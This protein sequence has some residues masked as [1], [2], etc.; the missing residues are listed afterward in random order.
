MPKM[1]P[2]SQYLG[3]GRG[4]F[5]KAL[6]TILLNK[7]SKRDAFEVAKKELGNRCVYCGDK[8]ALLQPD[9]LWPATI[10]GL[11]VPGNVV[12]ACPSCN[13]DRGSKHWEKYIRTSN[14]VALEKSADEIG[15]QVTEIRSYMKKYE[16]EEEP[17]IEQMLTKEEIQLRDNFNILLD[18]L[19]QGI[20]AKLNDPQEK[21]VQFR[22]CS[23]MFDDL[24]SVAKKYKQ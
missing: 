12:P 5:R 11:F 1:K 19:S 15:K 6:L 2:V 3:I 7:H 21:D 23:Q 18:A 13:S 10:G 17:N 8:N 20:R 22:D 14:R 16:T 24:L 9:L 4:S